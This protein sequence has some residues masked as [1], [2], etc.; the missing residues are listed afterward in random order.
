MKTPKIRIRSYQDVLINHL[1]DDDGNNWATIA[2]IYDSKRNQVA[3]GASVASPDVFF[4][5]ERG[6]NTSLF[7]AR[8]ALLSSKARTR[9]LN[10]LIDLNK[11]KKSTLREIMNRAKINYINGSY[12]LTV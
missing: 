7:R 2:L 11:D 3:I 10:H 4:D 5:K 8:G 6:R 9:D 1:K 12:H